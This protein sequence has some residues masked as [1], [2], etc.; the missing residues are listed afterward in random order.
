MKTPKI[1]KVPKVQRIMRSQ[2]TDRKPN[3]WLTFVKAYALEHKEMSYGDVL[4]TCKSA[5]VKVPI[6][7]SRDPNVPRKLNRW[8]EHINKYKA[9]NPAWKTTN[10]Y[11]QILQLCK[12][13]YKVSTDSNKI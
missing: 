6:V 13:S 7:K 10:T 3:P 1:P 12:E 11:K 2:L 5:Y 4:K 8:M 9:E